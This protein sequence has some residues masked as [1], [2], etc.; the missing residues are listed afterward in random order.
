VILE[1]DCA[2]VA[3]ALQDKMENRSKLWDIYGE[4]KKILS[5]FYDNHVV[6]IR[7]ESN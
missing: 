6:K 1:V 4:T 7:R 5:K 3:T 2:A